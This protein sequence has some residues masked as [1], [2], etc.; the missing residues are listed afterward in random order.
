MA[1]ALL[2]PA[3]VPALAHP[4]RRGHSAGGA[5][6]RRMTGCAIALVLML[7]LPGCWIFGNAQLQVFFRPGGASVVVVLARHPTNQLEFVNE[8][9]FNDDE[10]RTLSEMRKQIV[11]GDDVLGQLARFGF[12]FTDFSYFFDSTQ[13]SDFCEAINNIKNNARCL[14]MD[15]RPFSTGDRHNWTYREHTDRHCKIGEPFAIV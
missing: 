1:N 15:R 12:E 7:L 3:L 14:A 9:F 2:S 5:G 4:K 6:R 10:R 11:F 13:A 8:S